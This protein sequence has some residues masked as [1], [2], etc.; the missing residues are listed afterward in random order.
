MQ[1]VIHGVEVDLNDEELSEGLKVVGVK[2]VGVQ[3]LR[4]RGVPMETVVVTFREKHVP[5][6]VTFGYMRFRVKV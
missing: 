1:G 2:V 5:E 6:S 4:S 3:R